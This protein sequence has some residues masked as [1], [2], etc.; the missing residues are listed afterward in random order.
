MLILCWHF[1]GQDFV[2][3]IALQHL[4]V[5]QD[6]EVGWFG[7]TKQMCGLPVWW[8]VITQ[9]VEAAAHLRFCMHTYIYVRNCHKPLIRLYWKGKAHKPF[10]HFFGTTDTIRRSIILTK[11]RGSQS[12]FYHQ[13][14]GLCEE[15]MGSATAPVSKVTMIRVGSGPLLRFSNR[16]IVYLQLRILI[17]EVNI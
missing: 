11:K 2:V 12:S 1:L 13:K 17:Q 3:S 15:S 16:F 6:I 8:L 14:Q 10:W 7:S 9:Y 4:S 5:C